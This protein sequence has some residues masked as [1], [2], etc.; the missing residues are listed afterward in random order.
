MLRRSLFFQA[1][2][3]LQE[4]HHILLIR[5]AVELVQISR[6]FIYFPAVLMPAELLQNDPGFRFQHLHPGKDKIKRADV[7]GT[8]WRMVEKDGVW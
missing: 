7:Q 3:L 6:N 4:E 1:E 5:F 2:I 8:I